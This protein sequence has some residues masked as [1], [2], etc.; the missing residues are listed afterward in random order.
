MPN[1]ALAFASA[2]ATPNTPEL[3]QRI[4][5]Y[6]YDPNVHLSKPGP[7]QVT[8]EKWRLRH[9]QRL[10]KHTSNPDGVRTWWRNLW[11]EKDIAKLAHHN[12]Q[13]QLD[14]KILDEVYQMLPTDL[15]RDV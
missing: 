3:Q 2:A 8:C 13:P 11:K 14:G 6:L 5:A 7:D 10:L 1:T 4:T 15:R 9:E 12:G